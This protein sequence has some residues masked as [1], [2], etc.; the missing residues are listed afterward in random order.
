VKLFETFLAR[1]CQ[2]S[3]YLRALPGGG[4]QDLHMHVRFGPAAKYWLA[5][6]AELL[7]SFFQEHQGYSRTLQNFGTFQSQSL[8]HLAFTLSPSTQRHSQDLCKK[9]QHL[10]PS[11]A[12]RSPIGKGN[13]KPILSSAVKALWVVPLIAFVSNVFPCDML[14]LLTMFG[15]GGETTSRAMRWMNR[16]D[17]SAHVKAT[18]HD[19][20]GRLVITLSMCVSKE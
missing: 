7:P 2:G 17:T 14:A 3:L 11:A 8:G 10:L 18:E 12:Q 4:L 15:P 5:L 9:H 13:I 20:N 6:K 16:S 1:L 19:G